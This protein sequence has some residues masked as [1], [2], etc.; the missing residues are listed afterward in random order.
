MKQQLLNLVSQPSTQFTDVIAWID[1][2]YSYTP[3]RFHNGE[4][5]NEANQNNGSCKVFALA[6]LLELTQQETL[7]LFCEHYQAVLNHPAASDHQN[8]RQFISHGFTGLKFDGR[9]LVER[10]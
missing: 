5:L 10:S 7:G 9:A 3:T 4:Q 8:I 2:R 1:E 6:L